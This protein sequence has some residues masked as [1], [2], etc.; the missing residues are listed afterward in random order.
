MVVLNNTDAPHHLFL[1]MLSQ[2]FYVISD[3]GIFAT[4]HVREVVDGLNATEKIFLSQLMYTMQLTSEKRDGTQMVIN[5][6]NSTED[7]SL[8]Q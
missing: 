4:G 1:S 5:S 7:I 6:T 2:A 8:D 3:H